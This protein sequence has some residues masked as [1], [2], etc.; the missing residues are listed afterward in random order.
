MSK[1]FRH[2]KFNEYC[3][4]GNKENLVIMKEL[5]K[6]LENMTPEEYENFQPEGLAVARAIS[7]NDYVQDN[8]FEMNFC[9]MCGRK[10]ENV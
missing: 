4:N 6:R 9:P 1:P 10:L 7:S 3:R 2:V 5:L 8:S